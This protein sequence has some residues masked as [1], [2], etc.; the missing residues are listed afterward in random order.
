MPEKIR[1]KDIAKRA[2]VSVGTVDRVLHNR[3]N[4]S[5]DAAR[6]VQAVL[7][8]MN[9]KPNMYASALAHNKQYDFYMLIPEHDK[10]A[11]WN[12]VEQGVVHCEELRRDFHITV[13]VMYY[14]RSV[15][16]SLPEVGLRCLEEKPDGVVLVPTSLDATRTLTDRLHE[17]NIPFVM[18]DSYMPDLRPLAFFGQDSFQSGYFAARMFMLL[19]HKETDVML[20]RQINDGKMVSKQQ[21]NREVGFRH[22]MAD[23]YPNINIHVVDLDIK[24]AADLFDEQLEDFFETHPQVHHCITLCSKASVVGNFLLRTNRRDVQIMGYDFMPQ[25]NKCMREGSISFL[26]CQHAFMQG[27]LCIDTLF[28]AI[29]LKHEVT[30][31]NY[32]PIELLTPENLD[33]YR[34]MTI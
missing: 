10:E 32:M 34:R 3:S 5:Q 28:R 31:V 14:D 20:M 27:Y 1:I 4:V 8:E 6:K 2:G 12:E 25:N 26:V 22:Y 19:A 30:P 9:Y 24:S 13:H 17:E 16:E 33:F 18:L 15:P 21:A 29:V 11:Y 23:H 7:E